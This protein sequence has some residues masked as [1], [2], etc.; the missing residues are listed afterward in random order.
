MEC[1][2]FSI[3]MN[4]LKLNVILLRKLIFISFKI[5]KF[6]V[7]NLNIYKKIYKNN[8]LKKCVVYVLAHF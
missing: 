1:Y 8:L 7:S 2:R 5:M 4:L 3:K 6:Y